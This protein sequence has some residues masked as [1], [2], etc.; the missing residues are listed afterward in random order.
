MRHPTRQ[1]RAH[2]HEIAVYM[3]SRGTV[4]SGE[5]L[6]KFEMSHKT[7]RRR[8][9]AL[10]R[11]GIRFVE[12]RGSFYR[13]DPVTGHSPSTTEQNAPIRTHRTLSTRAR[14]RPKTSRATRRRRAHGAPRRVTI[15]L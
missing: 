3:R 9:P 6:D 1:N 10:E 5:I 12:N 13:T 14:A 11:L 2:A 15:I 7:L 8:R 4:F